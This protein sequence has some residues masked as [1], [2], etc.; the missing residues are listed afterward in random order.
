MISNRI[1]SKNMDTKVFAP[2]HFYC[3][4]GNVGNM[5]VTR[6]R[7]HRQRAIMRH[8]VCFLYNVVL[9]NHSVK[10]PPCE[11][12]SGVSIAGLM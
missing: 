12:E 4:E 6:K 7:P 1:S 9:E 2:K 5:A 8:F 11:G 10:N 3:F